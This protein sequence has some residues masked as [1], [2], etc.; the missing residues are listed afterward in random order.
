MNEFVVK[1]SR[2]QRPICYNR[3]ELEL[4]ESMLVI[5]I[6]ISGGGFRIGFRINTGDGHMVLHF[7][8]R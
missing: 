2:F 7:L 8:E 3:K 1:S 6:G 5:N 4:S